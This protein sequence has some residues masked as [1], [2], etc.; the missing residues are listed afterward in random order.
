MKYQLGNSTFSNQK[1]IRT[2]FQNYYRA[3]S[4]GTV[5]QGD[6]NAVMIDLIK[7]HP[8]YDETWA[9]EFTIGVDAWGAKNFQCG[10]I[11]FSYNKC[12][13]S[14]SKEKNQKKNVQNSARVAIECQIPS[15]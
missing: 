10:N 11:T 9:N 8:E 13:L 14:Q 15:F 5:L 1:A 12:I 4:V 2:Y 3:N 6:H 7:R